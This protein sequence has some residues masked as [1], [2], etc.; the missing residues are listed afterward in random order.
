MIDTLTPTDLLIIAAAVLATIAVLALLVRR[1][2][3]DATD[4]GLI[5]TVVA[6]GV[7]LWRALRGHP[8]DDRRTPSGGSDDAVDSGEPTTY[9]DVS[10]RMDDA[11]NETDGLTD[12]EAFDLFN[13]LYDE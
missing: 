9:T 7:T 10:E 3:V 2:Y 12:D 13:E 6:A 4:A 8:A 5:A 11:E 1:G